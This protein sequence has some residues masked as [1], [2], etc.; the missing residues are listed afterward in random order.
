MLAF[1]HNIPCVF[2]CIKTADSWP[3]PLLVFTGAL[4]IVQTPL[5]GVIRQ[6]ENGFRVPGRKSERQV[7]GLAC[8]DCCDQPANSAK[9]MFCLTY[10]INQQKLKWTSSQQIIE[11]NL[12][13]QQKYF[14]ILLFNLLTTYNF[15]GIIIISLYNQQKSLAW[16]TFKIKKR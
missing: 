15:V 12:Y 16:L 1:K 13:Y 9:I 5:F 6:S 2:C 8:R 7:W 4:T 3:N 14:V 10:V 11:I